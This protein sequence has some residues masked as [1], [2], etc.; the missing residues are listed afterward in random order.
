MNRL[1]LSGEIH[2]KKCTLVICW[3]LRKGDHARVSSFIS[4]NLK[5]YK[6]ITWEYYINEDLQ[7]VFA[8]GQKP[9]KFF[10]LC[11]R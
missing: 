4:Q 8:I 10:L 5:R 9:K 7:E 1:T 3:F 6:N 11:A 2:T